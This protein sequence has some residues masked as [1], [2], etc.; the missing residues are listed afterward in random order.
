MFLKIINMNL[1]LYTVK[2]NSVFMK[3]IHT[4][5]WYDMNIVK[6]ISNL[7]TNEPI[8]QSSIM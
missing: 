7:K 8:K 6:D 2:K 3:Y 1:Y 4:L 5:L